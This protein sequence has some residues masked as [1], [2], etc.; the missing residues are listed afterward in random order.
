MG[1]TNLAERAQQILPEDVALA[2]AL[3]GAGDKN[4][5]LS[6]FLAVTFL[7]FGLGGF[8]GWVV[9]TLDW[10]SLGTPTSGGAF[11]WEFCAGLTCSFGYWWAVAVAGWE[12]D[13]SDRSSWSKFW[14]LAV[15]SGLGLA[16]GAYLYRF[17]PWFDIL[18]PELR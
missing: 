15:P 4:D 3:A 13:K 16:V 7:I 1:R 11:A 8:L 5:R 18:H 10:W 17:F 14:I 6:S 9:L 12:L 2:L